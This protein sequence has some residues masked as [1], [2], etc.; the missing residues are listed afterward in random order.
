MRVLI[1]TIPLASLV[2]PAAAGPGSVFGEALPEPVIA[3]V[4]RYTVAIHVDR[5]PEKSEPLPRGPVNPALRARVPAEV[6]E[7]FQRPPGPVSGLLVDRKG[8]VLTTFYN[9]SGVLKSLQVE[10]PGG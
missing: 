3:A 1:L 4:A 5:E 10:L 9:V 2:R 8:H 6:R 7:Y